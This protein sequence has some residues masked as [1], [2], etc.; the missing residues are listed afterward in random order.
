MPPRCR[1]SC[2][3]LACDE[4]WTHLKSL[5]PCDPVGEAKSLQ[6]DWQVLGPIIKSPA[7]EEFCEGCVGA[8]AGQIFEQS[9][10]K[11]FLYVHNAFYSSLHTVTVTIF[12]S[13]KI[14]LQ[15]M[16]NKKQDV[17]WCF[18]FLW[19]GGWI[20]G[21]VTWITLRWLWTRC[22]TTLHWYNIFSSM[23]TLTGTSRVAKA[24]NWVKHAEE[25]QKAETNTSSHT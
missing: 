5:A 11:Y 17:S 7:G 9:Q 1:S 12:F 24:S 13:I 20:Y 25:Q 4:F 18:F 6:L 23:L 8:V 21:T 10:I 16:Q 2:L 19:D 14:Y 22:G 15:Q 3:C